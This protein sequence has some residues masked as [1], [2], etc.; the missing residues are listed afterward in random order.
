MEHYSKW[1]NENG[2][3]KEGY[4][5]DSNSREYKNMQEVLCSMNKPD[6]KNTDEY[7]CKILIDVLIK[8]DIFFKLIPLGKLI[9]QDDIGTLKK[10]TEIDNYVSLFQLLT[11]VHDYKMVYEWWVCFNG[12]IKVDML[13]VSKCLVQLSK[14]ELEY[15][16]VVYTTLFSKFKNSAI[17]E[18][19]QTHIVIYINDILKQLDDGSIKGIVDENENPV[20]FKSYQE[21]FDRYQKE[22]A[23]A[24]SIEKLIDKRM[25]SASEHQEFLK[26]MRTFVTNM[27][28]RILELGD[29]P[30]AVD[31]NESETYSNRETVEG[32]PIIVSQT[33]PAPKPKSIFNFNP[34]KIPKTLKELPK[35]VI[36]SVTRKNRP[37]ENNGGK[38]RRNDR[39][40]R[41]KRT[42]K[43]ATRRTLERKNG[44]I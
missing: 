31:S 4:K 34:L 27:R 21:K 32:I 16:P 41:K 17:L 22:Y 3:L 20:V 15:L 29:Q 11:V 19:T 42:R 28:K 30:I 7:N 12:N 6:K 39:G 1:Y 37:S 23:E 26:N 2:T 36:A 40:V 9:L 18:H 25:I 35:K 10:S 33:E 43:L 5:L 14:R 38:R 13:T 24:D 8:N 44:K